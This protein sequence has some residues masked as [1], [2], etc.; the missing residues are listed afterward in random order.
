M[1]TLLAPAFAILDR[2]KYAGKFAIV[3]LLFA[4]LTTVLLT[5]LIAGQLGTIAA[6]RQAL[7]GAEALPRLAALTRDLQQHRGMSTS[8]AAG[9]QSLVAGIAAKRADV[10][11][12]LADIDAFATRTQDALDISSRLATLKSQWASV[13]TSAGTPTEV[14]Q[15]HT[16]LIESVRA[17][18]EHVGDSSKLVLEPDVTAFHLGD[19]AINLAPVLAEFHARVRGLGARSLADGALSADEAE[20]LATPL[21][22]I[23]DLRERTVRSLAVIKA[24]DAA[25]ASRIES[26]VAALAGAE[27]N[28]HRAVQETRAGR[29]MTS[30]E[31]FTL[32]S[33][34]VDKSLALVGAVIPAL[35]DNV[36]A[37][38]AAEQR[39]LFAEVAIVVVA[40]ALIIYL[41][42]GF[43]VATRR[44]VA[45]LVKA[46]GA[47]SAGDFSHRVRV[48]GRDEMAA[49][50]DG[51]NRMADSVGGLVRELQAGVNTLSGACVKLS[52]AS[53]QVAAGSE[54]Q[55]SA[56]QG[57]ASSVEQLSVSISSV[58]E[59]VQETVA[60][61]ERARELSVSGEMLAR[62]T[63]R[64]I[65]YMAD[66]VRAST[67]TIER[68]SEH[69]SRV[70]GI[71]RVI[72]DVADQ[73]NLLA[74]NAA[75]EAAR[76]GELGRGFAV[77]AD[78]VR[79]LAER[80]ATAT[81]EI[82]QVIDSIEKGTRDSVA[83]IQ[84][85]GTCVES[86][87]SHAQRAAAA[88]V[89]IQEGASTTLERI[90]TI[91]A[92]TR[93][94]R[95]ASH[96]IASSVESIAQM[97]DRNDQAVRDINAVVIDVEQQVHQVAALTG[98][99]K[100]A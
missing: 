5:Q 17:L 44:S 80:T 76:A 91:A 62:D 15:R 73:T 86:G 4:T 56:A 53:R 21:Y 45:A 3:G 68:L 13:S 57:T 37:R 25:L 92:A 33:D 100:V 71:V 30:Q 83:G 65:G 36:R 87:V 28:V 41:A 48:D 88:L 23:R 66:A 67:Q 34:P 6:T 32:A 98:R 95:S 50:G 90:A 84:S 97:V 22:A 64:E 29:T 99:F 2:F 27:E 58:S 89:E 7:T 70:S 1:N 51:F 61:S 52:E 49:I 78:E 38:M 69:S 10:D 94:Q 39:R 93:E 24:A 72:R 12:Q 54:Q 8:A 40:A 19:I 26:Q 79:K 18:Q 43:F 81:T 35:E 74:L 59:S 46:A 85:V 63:A 82:A 20:Q 77:V 75:I 16:D 14:F 47:C 31:F 42:V 9:N 55:S 60:A 11:R 96:D